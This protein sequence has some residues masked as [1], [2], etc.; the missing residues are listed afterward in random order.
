MIHEN[1]PELEHSGV[2]GMRWG[3][4]KKRGDSKKRSTSKTT[5]TQNVS[6]N[7]TRVRN[8]LAVAIVTLRVSQLTD[9][10]GKNAGGLTTLKN[11]AKFV[12]GAA[13]E[14]VGNYVNRYFGP[15]SSQVIDAVFNN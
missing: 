6:R 11:A 8:F 2:K 15:A 5:K 14:T 4:R 1:K 12:N 10:F 9:G 13:S 3:V 7:R